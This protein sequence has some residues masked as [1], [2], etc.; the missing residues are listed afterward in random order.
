M[1]QIKM[2]LIAIAFIVILLGIIF[3]AVK[4]N[5]SPIPKYEI[6]SSEG[7]APYKFSVHKGWISDTQ[8]EFPTFRRKISQ[9]KPKSNFFIQVQKVS[10]IVDNPN[11]TLDDYINEHLLKEY[12]EKYGI[13]D[14]LCE[15][16][17]V[18]G[19]PKV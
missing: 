2:V 5:K 15:D 10:D 18:D 13:V 11:I 12:K 1:K 8:Y 6:K 7:Y 19:M 17:K 16:T 4:A 3:G 14:V 9:N